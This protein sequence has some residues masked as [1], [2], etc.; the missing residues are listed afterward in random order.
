VS[1]LI[2]LPTLI[3]P[4]F[5]ARIESTDDGLKIYDVVRRK[6]VSLTP[7]EWVRQHCVHW[8]Q[9]RGY[10]L[11]RCSIE[12][13]VDKSGMRYDV[14]WVDASIRPFLLVECKAPDVSVSEDTLRQSAWYNLT[15]KAPYL[16]LTN[17]MAAHCIAV[18]ADGTVDVLQD[19]PGYP[20]N[21]SAS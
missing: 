13:R 18:A 7:E 15:L 3:F 14:M 12:R 8:L 17:G 19:V 4:S 2:A 20:M 16:L 1:E 10:P 6:Y 11:G 21:P 9:S 5:S